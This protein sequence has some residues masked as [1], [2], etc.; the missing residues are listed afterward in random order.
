M[1]KLVYAAA[2]GIAV[3]AVVI[4][5]LLGPGLAA[6]PPTG[7][8][9][10][11]QQQQQQSQAPKVTPP[12]IGIQEIKVEKVDDRNATVKVKFTVQNP[13]QATV[14]LES[15]Q[16]EVF[17]DNKAVTSGGVGE[18]AEGFLGG[19]ANLNPVVPGATI[20]PTGQSNSVRSSSVADA[21]DKM[22]SA[23]AEG[24]DSIS[25]TVAGRY[26]YRL[27]AGNFQTTFEEKDFSL[28]FP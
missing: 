13:N 7:G 25:Y 9:E 1:N 20:S 8:G 4:F 16:Y 3:A 14:I 26:A 5:F 23:A 28:T 21:W 12:A 27:T 22:T 11:A 6:R 18:V 19:Q 2:G 10:G 24:E 15:I 17:V